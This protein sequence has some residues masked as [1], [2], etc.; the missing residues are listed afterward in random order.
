M[1]ADLDGL[2]RAVVIRIVEEH[3]RGPRFAVARI[4][5]FAA[6][7]LS[8]VLGTDALWRARVKV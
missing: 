6:S 2:H 3:V 1:T 4:A 8:A 7:M 5:V